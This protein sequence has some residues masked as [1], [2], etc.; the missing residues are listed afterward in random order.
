MTQHSALPSAWHGLWRI[1][2]GL[3]ALLWWL[4]L[5]ACIISAGAWAALYFYFAP[6]IADYKAAMERIGSEKTGLQV[7][8][9]SVHATQDL[10]PQF[11]LRDVRVTDQAQ[12]YQRSDRR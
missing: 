5:A 11:E 10:I 6:H 4:L 12:H 2:F 7:R 1:A 3:V 8:I 9:G